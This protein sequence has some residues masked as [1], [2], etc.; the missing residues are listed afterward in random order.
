VK[1]DL[2]NVDECRHII[3]AADD[4]FG[5]I[6]ILVNAAATTE[7][8]SLWDTTP[9]Q[10]DRIMNV[11]TRAP[12]FLMQDVARIMERNNE[13]NNNKGGG[14]IINISSTASYGSMPMIAAYGMSKGALNVATKNAAYSLMWSRIRVNALAIGWMDSP[15]EDD[16]QQRL[17]STNSS[18]PST[19]SSNGTTT[20]TNTTNN[21]KEIAERNQPFG[22]L[23]KTNEV[24]RMIAFCASDESGMM[25]GCVI[26]FDQSVFGAGNAPVPPPKDEW[27]RANNG[28]T[29]TFD[30]NDNNDNDDNDN[31]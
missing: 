26:D 20:A 30:S 13:V 27:V 19:D 21:W 7:R 17:H 25:T 28:M 18:S 15:G 2:A 8:G 5:T 22:R 6:D 16:I 9:E 4:K 10:Y 11:N 12:F 29:F 14:S 24:A 23:L 1:A 3:S 31:K